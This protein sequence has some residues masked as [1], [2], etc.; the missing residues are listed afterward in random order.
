MG[1]F[2]EFYYKKGIECPCGKKH[3]EFQS[4]D[5]DCVLDWFQINEDGSLE[6]EDYKLI[7]NPEERNEWG[8][9]SFKKEILGFKK[10]ELTDTIN[11]YSSCGFGKHWIDVNLTY[12]NGH[13]INEKVEIEEME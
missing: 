11:I 4:K 8:V 7:S 2:D 1:L 5:L 10:L 13:L 12:M 9:P 3:H 6:V